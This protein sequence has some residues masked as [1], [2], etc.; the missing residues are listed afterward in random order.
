MIKRLSVIFLGLGCFVGCEKI[1]ANSGTESGIYRI[2]K[3][4]VIEPFSQGSVP[5][6]THRLEQDGRLQAYLRSEI[7]DLTDFEGREVVVIGQTESEKMREIFVVESLLIKGLEVPTE[8]KIFS[9]QDVAFLYPAYWS[10]T[11]SPDGKYYFIDE[12]DVARK[13]FL[14]FSAKGL[15]REDKSQDPN[16]EIA[17]FAGIKKVDTDQRGQD[18]QSISLWSKQKPFKYDFLLT[19]KID[20]IDKKEAFLKTLESFVEGQRA[21]TNL[22][23]IQ[24]QQRATAQLDQLENKAGGGKVNKMK[25]GV[26]PTPTEKNQIKTIETRTKTVDQSFQNLIDDR[27]F[28][29]KSDFYRFQIQVP[30]GYWFRNYGATDS[31]LGQIGFADEEITGRGVV[32]FW[33]EILSDTQ[34]LEQAVFSVDENQY[35]I[36]FPR[37]N[38]TKYR[39]RGSVKFKDAMRSIQT[40][41]INF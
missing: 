8:T 34:G 14:T 39:L 25:V 27:A 7:I 30:Y 35:E 15:T 21:V 36:V 23:N 11:S 24:N 18:I 41:L 10:Y 2:E 13:V 4:G 32:D 22:K 17:G 20:Q 5:S 26:D 40:G 37:N 38:Q 31:T 9:E 29:Y 12:T 19:T 16:I 3:E 33:L 28:T 6:I 1:P